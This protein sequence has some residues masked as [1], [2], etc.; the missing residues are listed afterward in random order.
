MRRFER[1]SFL[2]KGKIAATCIPTK[3]E[4]VSHMYIKP[5][6]SAASC[7]FLKMVSKFM[8]RNQVV[9][10]Y[11]TTVQNK[12]FKLVEGAT[13]IRLSR[14]GSMSGVWFTGSF[15]YLPPGLSSDCASIIPWNAIMPNLR[16]PK[17]S[18]P[19][20]KQFQSDV[21]RLASAP[22][23]GLPLPSRGWTSP[24]QLK[25]VPTGCLKEES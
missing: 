8:L 24:G 17:P 3:V 1:S 4:S 23:L 22:A 6:V 11:I 13:L 20:S 7:Q 15:I 21:R 5:S 18:R 14:E 10:Q 9:V 16:T 12:N 2:A 19:R 25:V